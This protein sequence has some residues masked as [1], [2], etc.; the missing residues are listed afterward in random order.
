MPDERYRVHGV[1]NRKSKNSKPKGEL[2][3]KSDTIFYD[4]V[5]RDQSLEPVAKAWLIEGHDFLLE[6][7]GGSEH[8]K[9]NKK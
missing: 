1:Q 8:S 4:M 9:E 5:Y 2:N 6:E 3:F 7:D